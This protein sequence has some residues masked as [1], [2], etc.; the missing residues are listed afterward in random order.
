MAELMYETIS[1]TRRLSA[2]MNRPRYGGTTDWD[3][4]KTTPLKRSSPLWIKGAM[5][6]HNKAMDAVEKKRATRAEKKKLK[7]HLKAVAAGG[8]GTPETKYEK[9]HVGKDPEAANRRRS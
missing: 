9:K 7:D 4:G 3:T 6:K 5:K 1:E 2:P 8:R